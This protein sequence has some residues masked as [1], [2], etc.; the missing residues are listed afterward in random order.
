MYPIGR[1]SSR[2]S[3]RSVHPRAQ[4]DREARPVRRAVPVVRAAPEIRAHQGECGVAQGVIRRFEPPGAGSPS[5][6]RCQQPPPTSLVASGQVRPCDPL[7]LRLARTAARRSSRRRGD[8]AGTVSRLATP[9]G[10]AVSSPY[11]AITTSSSVVARGE[12][13]GAGE[14]IREACKLDVGHP[15][16]RVRARSRRPRSRAGPFRTRR[17]DR[18]GARPTPRPR[19]SRGW[20]HTWNDSC[21]AGGRGPR[22]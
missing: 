9:A 17:F 13:A 11:R 2:S 6:N 12:R 5:P 19:G 18:G 21:R 14:P 20:P 1:G 3:S 4:A 16:D 7:S 10:N 8:G 15:Q 22:W